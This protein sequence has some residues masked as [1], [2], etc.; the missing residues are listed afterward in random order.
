MTRTGQP[1]SME[2]IDPKDRS[3]WPQLQPESDSFWVPGQHLDLVYPVPSDE[4]L[5]RSWQNEMHVTAAVATQDVL[6]VYTPPNTPV[7][8]IAS[9]DLCE[10]L[11][12][13]K[14]GLHEATGVANNHNATYSD[15]T[16]YDVTKVGYPYER[17]VVESVTRTLINHGQIQPIE[18][19]DTIT[20]ILRRWRD[21]GI[22]VIA[23]TS[24]LPG[25]EVATIKHT[26]AQSCNRQFDGML[27]P[28]NHAGGGDMTKAKAIIS[29]M[30]QASLEPKDLPLLHMD[31]A[32][33]HHSGFH[34]QRSSF[35]KNLFLLAPDYGHDLPHA[36][37]VFKKPVETFMGANALFKYLGVV[38]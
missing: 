32:D 21:N 19:I 34:E 28:R 17:S 22:W 24:T 30:R 4:E 29:L 16:W 12:H 6:G 13:T 7:K 26:L 5:R 38:K 35:G 10:M 2:G 11:R 31:D 37:F 36:D 18:E 1:V 9:V 27:L 23:N 20:G 33:L 25:C 15:G 8:A 3:T 14:K